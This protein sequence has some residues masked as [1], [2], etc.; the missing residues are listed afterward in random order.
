[1]EI[2]EGFGSVTRDELVEL[3]KAL[4]FGTPTPATGPGGWALV[5]QSIEAV[6][7]TATLQ[8]K[9]IRFFKAIPKPD[10]LL[11]SAV[12]EYTRQVALGDEL[13]PF[14]REGALPAEQTSRYER[15]FARVKYLAEM[16]RVT[17][18]MAAVSTIGGADAITRESVNGT[19]NLLA[20]VERALFFGDSRANSE[21]WDGVLA[22]LERVFPDNIIDLKGE[23]LTPEVCQEV[24]AMM[25]EAPRYAYPQ[26]LWLSPKALTK[27]ATGAGGQ[28]LFFG[29]PTRPAAYNPTLGMLPRG[30]MGAHGEMIVYEPDIFLQP[31]KPQNTSEIGLAPSD[32]FE[33]TLTPENDGGSELEP[34]IYTYG[35]CAFGAS[36]RSAIKTKQ[37]TV[38]S[39]TKQKVTLAITKTG[40][41]NDIIYFAIFRS[42]PN[43]SELYWLKDVACDNDPG[44]GNPNAS[45]VDL[46]QY[47]AGCSIAVLIEYDRTVIA[48]RRLLPLIRVPL[49]KIDLSTRFAL[50]MFAMPLFET[51]TKI[52]VIKNIATE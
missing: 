44:Q 8:A 27:V 14:V 3:R 12:H 29:D 15:Q 10:E 41:H 7:A 11:Q 31:Y 34:G 47:R 39:A 19:L 4:E 42:K 16:R 23:A 22:T 20:K 25:I 38:P 6:L 1:M 51:P 36:G 49:A 18:P 5:P 52:A 46:N 40:T 17:D 21:S 50:V 32:E 2:R 37:V 45:Y 28:L 13:P 43:G 33:F 30:F 24:S 48:F 9:H 35:V 26:A